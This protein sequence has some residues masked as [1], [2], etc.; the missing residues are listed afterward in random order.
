MLATIDI[1]ASADFLDKI[2]KIKSI[3]DADEKIAV[4]KNSSESDNDDDKETNFTMKMNKQKIK[5]VH[6]LQNEVPTRWNS[7]YQMIDSVMHLRTKVA[8]ALKQTGHYKLCLKGHELIL[9]EDLRNFL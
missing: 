1:I 3:L 9:L 4:D 7:S 5:K 6:Q 2:S 8:N